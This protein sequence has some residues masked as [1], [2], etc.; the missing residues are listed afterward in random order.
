MKQD[1]ASS[2]QKVDELKTKIKSRDADSFGILFAVTD[3]VLLRK[4]GT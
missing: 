4:A 3:L 2:Q 1:T